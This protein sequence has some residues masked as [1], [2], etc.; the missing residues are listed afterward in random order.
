[1]NTKL[2]AARRSLAEACEKRDAAYTALEDA[3]DDTPGDDLVVL[4]K[5]FDE[6]QADAQHGAAPVVAPVRPRR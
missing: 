6:A 2:E 1:M 4:T 5:V 3:P